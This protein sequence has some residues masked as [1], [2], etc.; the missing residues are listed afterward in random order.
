MPDCS[1]PLLHQVSEAVLRTTWERQPDGT[2][3]PDTEYKVLY[4]ETGTFT[5]VECEQVVVL[6]GKTAKLEAVDG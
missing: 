1:H 5:C 2:Y 3:E 4:E 6:D